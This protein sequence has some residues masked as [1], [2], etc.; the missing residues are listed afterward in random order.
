VIGRAEEREAIERLLAG[1]RDGRSGILLLRGEPG[2][3]KSA[4]LAYAVTAAADLCVLRAHGV[5]SESELDFSGLHELFAPVLERLE[6]L[7]EPQAEALRGALRLAPAGDVDRFAVAAATLSLLAAVADH[8]AV[9]VA[10]DDVQWLD[11]ASAEALAFAARRLAA[12]GVAVLG[13]LVEGAESPLSKARFH[14]LVVPGLDPAAARELLGD[15]VPERVAP[16]VAEELVAATGG[17]ALALAELAPELTADQLAG[18]APLGDHLPSGR[19]IEEAFARRLAPLGDAARTAFL[20]AAAS[21]SERLD[22]IMPAA[23]ALG[24]R[25]DAFEAIEAVG[26]LSIERGR[27]M[28]RHPLLRSAVYSAAPAAARRAAHRALAEAIA[29]EDDPERVWHQAA[30]TIAPDERVAAAL[31]RTAE[32]ARRRSGYLAAA[33]ALDRAAQLTPPG[34]VRARRLL[35]AGQSARRAGRS[36]AG[37]LLDQAWAEATD[38]LLRFDVE[39]KRAALEAWSGSMVSAAQ[40]YVDSAERLDQADP[41]REARALSFGAAAWGVA[42]ELRKAVDTASRAVELTTTQVDES[43]R[44]I[45]RETLGSLLVECGESDK[46]RTLVLEAAAWYERQ[47]EPVDSA[48]VALALLWLEEYGLARRLIEPLIPSARRASD[49]RMLAA[50]LELSA[51]LAFRTGVWDRA[52]TAASESAQ[53]AEATGETTQLA[54]SLAVQAT[55]EAAR[56][57][58]ACRTHA[59]RAAELAQ[60]GGLA[61]VTEHAD[62]AIGLLELG[63]GNGE[64]AVAALERVA[65]ADARAGRGEPGVFPW[66]ADLVEAYLL[67]GRAKEAVGATE[68]LEGAATA[69]GRAWA[70]AAALR[71]RGLLAPDDELDAPFG[72]ALEA[73]GLTEAPFQVARTELAYGR[74]LRRA[75]RRVD[76]REQLRRA[77]ATFERLGARPWLEAA[78]RELAASGETLRAA[79][80]DARDLLT[81][82]E[83]QIASL[84]ANG[85]TNREVA[86]SLFLSPKTI[87]SH[88]QNAYRKLGVHSR[89]Q[90]SK[91]LAAEPGLA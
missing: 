22:A 89:T 13:T 87:E 44:P 59:A 14:E 18:T 19:A 70:R 33:R 35:A 78:R 66:G 12:E 2:V 42:G 25:E 9:L 65:A 84:V 80:P 85:M 47:H 57:D 31:E 81:P 74:R 27:V 61:A 83:L 24:A 43:T 91:R 30:A 67:A 56:G 7:P 71:C 10:L 69:T 8:G 76:A 64:P 34:D 72:A 5:E 75:R 39:Q 82:Q 15:G 55:I 16:R 63:L 51:E 77:A 88:L 45:A 32:S 60:R 28:F 73:H 17:N 1:A 58:D 20:V 52:A 36:W 46:G 11:D 86:A 79:T 50:A 41:E 4:L 53:L 62:Y 90:L 29:D 26:L 48:F 23:A 6:E 3:G 40:R 21:E 38:P 49:L 54:Y 68:R 37:D